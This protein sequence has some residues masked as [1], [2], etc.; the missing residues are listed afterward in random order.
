MS[1][2]RPVQ[3][4][5]MAER[6]E[7]RSNEALV[8]SGDAQE[9]TQASPSSEDNMLS[10]RRLPCCHAIRQARTRN[11]SRSVVGNEGDDQGRDVAAVEIDVEAD[12]GRVHRSQR[13]RR[14]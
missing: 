5:P 10:G 11:R 1:S 2:R 14:L 7:D 4:G 3:H 8:L 13:V 12:R 9:S 6:S